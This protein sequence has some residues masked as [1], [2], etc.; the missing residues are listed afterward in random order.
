MYMRFIDLFCG[1]GGL[2]W[3]LVQA[4]WT[5]LCG[6]DADEASLRTYAKNIKASTLHINIAHPSTLQ[7]L[8]GMYTN[9][10][11]VV[12]GPPCQ[13]FSKN[14]SRKKKGDVRLTMPHVFVDMATQFKP[15][16]IILEEVPEFKRLDGGNI[17]W[18][19][20]H[21]LAQRGYEYVREGTL[22]ASDYGAATTRRRHIIVAYRNEVDAPRVWPPPKTVETPKSVRCAWREN[23]PRG[24]D[25]EPHSRPIRPEV[26]EK[27]A[28][29]DRAPGISTY[30]SGAYKPMLLDKPAVTLTTFCFAPGSGRFAV[31]DGIGYRR[32]TVHEAKVIQGFGSRS[33]FFLQPE[34]ALK[35]SNKAYRQIGN[36]VSPPTA[37]AIADALKR[38]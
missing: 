9:V 21:M 18:K 11:A 10:D 29:F 4:G 15:K 5:P 14:N 16:Y 12:G 8:L 17:H 19:T 3:G 1:A 37:R 7:T 25:A 20:I 35:S 23:P 26:Q 13:G 6:V 2:S 27:I 31:P 30:F 24:K 34:G 28:T 33:F 32:L 22:L 38:Y 36:S